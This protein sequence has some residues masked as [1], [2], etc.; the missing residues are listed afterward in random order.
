MQFWMG[1]QEEVAMSGPAGLPEI[2]PLYLVVPLM[3]LAIMFG[4]NALWAFA[5]AVRK[6]RSALAPSG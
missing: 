5:E 3:T 2:N 4:M 1:P 6:G